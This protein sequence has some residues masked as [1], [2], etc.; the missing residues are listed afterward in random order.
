MTMNPL[1]NLIPALIMGT[2]MVAH[3]MAAT[4]VT[5]EITNNT[6][7]TLNMT[8]LL[9]DPAQDADFPLSAH[10]VLPKSTYILR[11]AHQRN[12]TYPTSGWQPTLKKVKPIELVLNYKM[13]NFNFECQMQTRFQAP[14]VIGALEPSY[15]PDWK[16]RANYTGN[17]Q[18][19]CRTE[20]TRKMLEPPFNY[21]V[22][23]IVE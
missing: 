20:I 11:V 14:I 17:G 18:F 5:V 8:N 1:K 23:L 4:E 7:G 3:T 19:T 16:S 21:T 15:K 9:T 13:S 10:D 6:R 12:Y 22:R 2:T